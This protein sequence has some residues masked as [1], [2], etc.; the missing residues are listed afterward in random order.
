MG[1]MERIPPTALPWQTAVAEADGEADML[2]YRGVPLDE[3][4]GQVPF[5][6]VWGLLVADDFAVTPPPAERFPLPAH[7]GDV[8]ADVQSALALLAPVWGFRPLHDI[9]L[10][11]ARDQLARASS[12]ALS[13]VAQSARGNDVPVVPQREVDRSHDIVE[14]F[15]IRWRGD[16]DPRDVAALSAYFVAAAE[17][18]MSPSTVTARVIASTGAD[19]AACLSGAVGAIS[20]PLHG[21]APARAMHMMER[22]AAGADPGREVARQLDAGHR[23]MGFGHTVYRR[24]DPRARLLRATCRRLGSPLC[25]A[26]EALEAAALAALAQRH[27]EHRIA[28][29]MELWAAVL[30]HGAGVPT[31]LFAALFTCARTAGWSAHILEQ[32]GHVGMR[33][34]VAQYVGPA[35]RP[36]RSVPGWSAMMGA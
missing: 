33:R 15:L 13:F 30:L 8:R 5:G 9:T 25:E 18:G 21:G 27:P 22:I 7:T 1:A 12:M 23:L 6:P 14:R 3:L 32:A 2:R 28:T 34:P 26:A 29:N 16:P 10:A 31:P 19:V 4:V 11:Q 36:A 24:E 35:A 20:G 17:H